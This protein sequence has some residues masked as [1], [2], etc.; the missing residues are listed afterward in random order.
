MKS[1]A[2]IDLSFE[3]VEYVRIYWQ[4]ISHMVVKGFEYHSYRFAN[5]L[6]Q[7]LM[8]SDIKIV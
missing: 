8:G 7:A 1:I 5:D 2:S 3:N 6:T 4:G